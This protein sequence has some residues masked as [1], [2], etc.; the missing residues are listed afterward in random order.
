MSGP[1]VVR[2]VTRDEIVEICHGLIARLDS[3][4]ERWA[5]VAEGEGLAGE[6]EVAATR[7]RRD[8]LAS[9]IAVDR[10]MELQK[11]APQEIE[12]L[13]ADLE[14][15]RECA[16][17]LA[18]QARQRDRREVEAVRALLASLERQGVDVPDDVRAT[19]KRASEGN[20]DP[21]EAFRRGRAVLGSTTPTAV[22]HELA[23]RLKGSQGT[24]SI[25]DWITAQPSEI[26]DQ[27][28][29]QIELHI[30]QLAALSG[31]AAAAP[32]EARLA[33]L[34]SPTTAGRRDLL[35]DSLMVDLATALTGARAAAEVRAKLDE[36]FSELREIDP[37]K[38]DQ[39]EAKK[40]Q[41]EV[42][43]VDALL[44]EA[45]AALDHTRAE[46]AA[47]ARREAV[48]KGLAELGYELGATMNAAWVRD[49]RLVLKKA[50]RPDYGV[51][52]TG[53]V[54]A[55]KLQMRVIGFGTT[56]DPSRDRDAETLW[57]GDVEQLRVTLAARGA[58]LAI[59]KALPAGAAPVKRI[60]S[61][62]EL[63]LMPAAVPS[64][65]ALHD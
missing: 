56:A 61:D 18:A 34:A 38:V 40:S 53:G 57:C 14:A 32:F 26:E 64:R 55:T 27:R 19:L 24:R 45:N 15:K 50:A 62:G 10:F 42:H 7:A 4:I 58:D 25:D 54:N 3:V 37:A 22:Q 31:R 30:E 47:S 29:N 28:R 6:G 43:D 13:K 49:G 60:A 63:S 23:Q 8:Q 1:K 51:E 46:R 59:E 9:L 35:M 41:S 20:G 11:A 39:L 44:S 33:G 21:A 65:R 2:I 52:L 5:R 48:L 17:L 12:F 36:A 16:A